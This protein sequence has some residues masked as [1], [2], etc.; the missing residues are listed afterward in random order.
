MADPEYDEFIKYQE[1]IENAEKEEEEEE[2]EEKAPKE[3][4]EKSLANVLEKVVD[5]D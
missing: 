2:E 5:D 1:R 3:M 4:N